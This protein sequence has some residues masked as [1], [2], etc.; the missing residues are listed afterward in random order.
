VVIQ[1]LLAAP[2]ECAGGLLLIG[3]VP[4]PD[5]NWVRLIFRKA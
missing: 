2:H 5:G 4:W 3:T 1:V